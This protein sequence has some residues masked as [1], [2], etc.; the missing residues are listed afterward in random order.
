[1]KRMKRRILTLLMSLTMVFTMIPVMGVPVYA[2]DPHSG[3]CGDNLTWNYDSK[4]K[5][6]TISGTGDMYDYG[7]DERPN[8]TD[9][10]W[11]AFNAE[12][13]KVIVEEGV[14][15]LGNFAFSAYSDYLVKL[16]EVALPS[17]LITVGQYAFGG[18]GTDVGELK[19]VLPANLKTIEYGAF[20]DSAIK[21]I[22]IPK[23]VKKLDRAFDGAWL[24]Q[25]D[26]GEV[27]ELVDFTFYR[28]QNLTS[29]KLPKTLK[30]IGACVFSYVPLK[31]V[32]IPEGV[33]TLG[34]PD[35]Y[36]GMSAFYDCPNL[37]RVVIPSTVTYMSEMEFQGCEGLKEVDYRGTQEQWNQ[38]TS[39]IAPDSSFGKVIN[40]PS[41][42]KEYNYTDD[43]TS[44]AGAE[45][46]LSATTFTYNGKVQRPSIKTVGGK[47]LKE[48]VDYTAAWSNASSK[49][50]GKYMV[51]IT[52]VGDCYG[53]T[54]ATYS[55]NKAAN[56][57]KVKGKTASVKYKKLK[58]RTQ[59]L[60][61]TRAITVT[62]PQGKLTNKKVS[63]TYTK[64]KSVKM[65]KKAFK[66]YKKQVAKKITVN[67][68]TGKVTI[69]KKLKKGTYSVKVK[70]K[71]AG[72]AN[73]NPSAWKTVTFKIKVK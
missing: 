40:N 4:E 48:G 54:S 56:T 50:A 17:T 26:L 37:E 16:S 44:I 67:A 38:L 1:M 21:T 7:W 49:N 9:T 73:Y 8:F 6:L 71:A 35:E 65:S 60:G 23:G 5:T 61:R 13:E 3:K 33:T 36:G 31:E 19:V 22:S 70:V 15:R 47:I 42:E 27:E 69:K 72:N 34:E 64:A 30:V 2:D 11:T 53:K 20:T 52:G 43:S 24:E 66:K 18:A 68:K 57:M 32:V 28:C 63:V 25:I 12:I 10:P 14:T 45:V 55:I 51:T 39:G 29:I 58:K 62:S 41:I 46:I 59:T